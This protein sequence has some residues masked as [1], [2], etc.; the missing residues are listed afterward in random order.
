M[1][2]RLTFDTLTFYSLL[3]ITITTIYCA[4]IAKGSFLFKC[5]PLYLFTTA[6]WGGVGWLLL[7]SGSVCLSFFRNFSDTIAIPNS[8]SYPSTSYSPL[9]SLVVYIYFSFQFHSLLLDNVCSL[10]GFT[11][12]Q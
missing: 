11:M 3:N 12:D 4:T 10:H 2:R 1:F 6:N 7:L 8:I 5:R 9:L